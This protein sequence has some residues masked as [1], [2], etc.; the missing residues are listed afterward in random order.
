VYRLWRDLG[1]ALGALLAGLTADAFGIS[2]A[3][4]FVGALTFASG[5]IVSARMQETRS[6]VASGSS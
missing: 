3:L 5:M 2:A 4:W 6:A 1:Y